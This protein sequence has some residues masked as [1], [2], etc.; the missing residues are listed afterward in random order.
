[1][2]N[3]INLHRRN[4]T[5]RMT[6][7]RIRNNLI[8]SNNQDSVA[9][10][11]NKTIKKK[12]NH[13]ILSNRINKKTKDSH[14]KSKMSTKEVQNPNK[15]IMMTIIDR[16]RINNEEIEGKIEVDVALG[17]KL[18]LIQEIKVVAVEVIEEVTGMTSCVSQS[19]LTVNTPRKTH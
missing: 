3:K 13:K 15:L 8:S 14:K 6:R 7:I 19:I 1:M 10:E 4:L 11:N 5:I 18:L 12:K 17:R 2:T 9:V 16:L